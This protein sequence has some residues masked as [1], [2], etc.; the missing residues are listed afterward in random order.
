MSRFSPLKWIFPLVIRLQESTLNGGI[1]TLPIYNS[2]IQKQKQKFYPKS[3]AVYNKCKNR[4]RMSVRVKCHNFVLGQQVDVS[5]LCQPKKA[6]SERCYA[7]N[8]VY[9]LAFICAYA[10]RSAF[11]QDSWARLPL[12]RKSNYYFQPANAAMHGPHSLVRF[13]PGCAGRA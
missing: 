7:H 5:F 11:M 12:G 13:G 10:Q 2:E 4:M 3:F 8:F 6:M 9:I 1:C